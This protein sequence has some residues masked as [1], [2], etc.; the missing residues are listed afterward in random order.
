MGH[1]ALR[2]GEKMLVSKDVAYKTKTSMDLYPKPYQGKFYV[3]TQ[4][5]AFRTM[6]GLPPEFEYELSEIESFSVGMLKTI[7]LNMKD[8]GAHTLTGMFNKSLIQG[9]LDVGIKQV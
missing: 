5:V 6:G 1:L 2:E 7:H 9:L 8:S 3:T 4:R